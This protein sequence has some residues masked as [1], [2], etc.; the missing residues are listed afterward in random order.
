MH[1]YFKF[2]KSF[3]I[4]R[5]YNYN[6]KSSNK[7]TIRDKCAAAIIIISIIACQKYTITNTAY[8]ES[9]ES[10]SLNHHQD[11]YYRQDEISRHKTKSSR[12]WVTYQDDVYDITGNIKLNLYI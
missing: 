10:S 12:I 1:S 8:L 6:H 9:S 4:R 5:L 3:S 7:I 11:T 2:A